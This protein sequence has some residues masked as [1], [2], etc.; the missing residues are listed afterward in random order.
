MFSRFSKAS[1]LNEGYPTKIALKNAAEKTKFQFN[2]G[3]FHVQAFS[4]NNR[5][6]CRLF[7]LKEGDS[8]TP[9][10]KNQVILNLSSIIA[11]RTAMKT[12]MDCMEQ[13]KETKIVLDNEHHILGSVTPF[14]TKVF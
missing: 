6:F 2:F 7:V 14:E 12:L 4:V 5:V 11:L 13:E 10:A 8:T 1:L 9:A 3:Q